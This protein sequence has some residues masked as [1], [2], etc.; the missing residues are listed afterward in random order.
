MDITANCDG[1][2]HF[3]QIGLLLQNLGTVP[4]NPKC[5]FFGKATFSA[6]VLFE[7]L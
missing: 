7:K 4:N 6:E 5:L 1:R 3:Q 2:I